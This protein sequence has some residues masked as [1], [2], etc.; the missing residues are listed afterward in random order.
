M[1]KTE[2]IDLFAERLQV[3]NINLTEE[4]RLDSLEEWDSWN[5]LELMTMVDESFQVILT[6][7]DL[8]EIITLKDLMQ[9]IGEQKIE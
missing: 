4:T 9:K 1:T 2:F 3:K 6:A 8:N 7:Q 5:R